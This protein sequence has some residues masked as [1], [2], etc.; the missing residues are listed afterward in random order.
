MSWQS[1]VLLAPGV[2]SGSS[3]QRIT[4]VGGKGGQV[5][6]RKH[7][8][9]PSWSGLVQGARSLA[10]GETWWFFPARSQSSE[11]WVLPPEKE[12]QESRD[13]HGF[14]ESCPGL[15]SPIP[16]RESHPPISKNKPALG[17]PPGGSL[18]KSLFSEHQYLWPGECRLQRR[19]VITESHR[20]E[21]EDLGAKSE[22]VW[23]PLSL[24]FP[25]IPGSSECAL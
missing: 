4:S 5:T 22:R 8:T 19:A 25:T 9:N 20:E 6:P 23:Y 21:A 10:W 11:L 3:N 17:L 12:G 13:S 2:Q 15:L 1:V 18:E 24:V 16:T 7:L 14:P